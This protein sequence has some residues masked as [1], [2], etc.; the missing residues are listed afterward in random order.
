[1][2]KPSKWT[3]HGDVKVP[4]QWSQWLRH[5]RFEPPTIAEL[6]T[7]VVR[8]QRI[9]MLAAEAD[10]RWAS[11]PSFLDAPDKQQ[12]VQMLESKDHSA[13]IRQANTRVEEAGRE[14]ERHSIIQSQEEIVSDV[15]AEKADE[16]SPKVPK[17]MKKKT[18]ESK[19]SPWKEAAR[20]NPGDDWQPKEWTP[21]PARRRG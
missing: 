19:D 12:P 21:S 6:Q 20:G 3:H 15:A 11:K 1:M 8:Q 16:S 2:L 13:G 17:R 14:S 9:K 5:T 7:D 10:A 18:K 4:P